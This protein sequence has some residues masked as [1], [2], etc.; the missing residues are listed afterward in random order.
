[1]NIFQA[2]TTFLCRLFACWLVFSALLGLVY[3]A[4]G[5]LM[6]V[7]F[8]GGCYSW[9]GAYAERWPADLVYLF[10]A[11]LIFRYSSCIGRHVGR[12]LGSASSVGT[13]DA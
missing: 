2:A 12:N 8:Y 6:R 5:L 11:W 7:A 13:Q 4:I 1:M 9:L 10:A 3:T